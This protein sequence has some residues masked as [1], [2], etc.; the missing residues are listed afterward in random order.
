MG[1]TY[2]VGLVVVLILIGC[3]AA[4]FVVNHQSCKPDAKTK[5]RV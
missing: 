3:I 1:S 2:I 5:Y 4:A